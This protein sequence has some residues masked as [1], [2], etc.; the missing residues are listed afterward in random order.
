MLASGYLNEWWR[1]AEALGEIG[2][3]RAVRLLAEALEDEYVEVRWK[4]A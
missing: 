2:D 1:A 4:A 3:S